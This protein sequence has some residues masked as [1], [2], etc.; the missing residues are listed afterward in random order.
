MKIQS[1]P[2]TIFAFENPV[3]QS[4]RGHH[5]GH[6]HSRR[7][8]QKRKGGRKTGVNNLEKPLKIGMNAMK[9]AKGRYIKKNDG[10]KKSVLKFKIHRDE[11]SLDQ[12]TEFSRPRQHKDVGKRLHRKRTAKDDFLELG[13]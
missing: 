1:K 10:S 4:G 13:N 3:G 2:G 7:A 11:D 8:F 12:N 6:P 9:K 5:M